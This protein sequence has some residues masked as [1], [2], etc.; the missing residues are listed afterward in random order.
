M[1]ILANIRN[2]YQL[3]ILSEKDVLKNPI[4]QTNKWLEEA[5]HHKITE[6]TAMN[7]ST[8]SANGRPSSRIV[9]LKEI[10]SDGFV[11]F[12]NYDSKKG[13]ELANNPYAAITLFWKE[14]ERQIRIEG[15]IQKI[16]AAESDHYFYSRPLGSRIGAIVSPQSQVIADRAELETQAKILEDYS[17]DLLRRPENW[18]GYK[19][20]P[21]YIEFWQGRSNRLHDRL[22]FCLENN[23]WSLK[24]LA[25]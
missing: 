22:A 23:N 6:P 13:H 9:L 24:R 25:P 17:E 10:A 4:E 2:D 20:L 18:G 3:N 5:L 14:L 8:V 15:K 21:D 12:T 7:L 19:L 1:G 16:T 11:F